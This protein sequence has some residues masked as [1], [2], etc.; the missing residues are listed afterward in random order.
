MITYDRLVELLDYDRNTGN[1]TW[2]KQ[3]VICNS[4]YPGKSAGCF[5]KDG[6]C[7]LRIDNVLYLRHRL[8]WLYE[9]KLWPEF[10]VDH[11]DGTP[12]NDFISNLREATR[13]DNMKNTRTMSNNTSGVKGVSWHKEKSKW[14]AYIQKGGKFKHLGYFDDKQQ[15]EN[16]AKAAREKL[17]KEFCNHGN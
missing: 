8:A 11:K 3:A 7:V 10:E 4:R 13:S 9:Y 15:A 14:R 2:K 16:A 6:Y 17:H 5:R 12:G 1:F